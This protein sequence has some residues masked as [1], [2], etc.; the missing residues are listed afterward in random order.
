MTGVFHHR[1]VHLLLPEE[2]L[3]EAA[4]LEEATALEEAAALEETSTAFIALR[5]AFKQS[6]T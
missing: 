6:T 1:I 4:A 3:E 2:V 5:G